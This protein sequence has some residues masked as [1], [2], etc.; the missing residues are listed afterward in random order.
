MHSILSHE[1]IMVI[2]DCFIGAFYKHL[3]C[4]PF[5]VQV[6]VQLMRIIDD[7]RYMYDYFKTQWRNKYNAMSTASKT[8]DRYFALNIYLSFTR[9][10]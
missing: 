10:E 8:T 6:T 1:Y 9:S 2:A 5:G 4:I 3:I 7:Y